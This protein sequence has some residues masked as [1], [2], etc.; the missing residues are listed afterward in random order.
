MKIVQNQVCP[1]KSALTTHTCGIKK[2]DV[3]WSK[4]GN[5]FPMADLKTLQLS[6]FSPF[7]IIITFHKPWGHSASNGIDLV[8]FWALCQK[9][10]APEA[11]CPKNMCSNHL[12]NFKKWSKVM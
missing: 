7:S 10:T 1:P 3:E 12:N 11:G 5:N 8:E 4:C 2:W 6:I 9:L